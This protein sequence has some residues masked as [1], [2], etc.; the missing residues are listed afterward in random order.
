MLEIVQHE[1][2]LG[3]PDPV[4]DRV[5]QVSDTRIAHGKAMRDCG[6]HELRIDD[7]GERNPPGAVPEIV[8]TRGGGGNRQPGLPRSPGPRQRQEP[9][10]AEQAPDFSDLGGSAKEAR[11]LPGQGIESRFQ[12]PQWREFGGQPGGDHLMEPHRLEVLE[13]MSSE[14]REPDL[15]RE[16]TL[17]GRPDRL[18]YDDLATV[19]RGLDARRPVDVDAHVIVVGHEHRPR[20]NADPHP[21]RSL[22]RPGLAGQRTLRIDGGGERVGRV[23]KDHEEA[24]AFGSPLRSSMG[25]ECRSKDRPMTCSK[26][27][28][29]GRSDA[30]LQ[31]ARAFDI[32]EQERHAA[33][34]KATV[35]AGRSWRRRARF[36][37]HRRVS[38]VIGASRPSS[39][40]LSQ[41]ERHQ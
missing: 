1:E 11:Q 33:G 25:A 38:A 36:G 40:R 32:G 5:D 17:K 7:G 10:R 14:V 6:S 23:A 4:R 20:V 30:L 34:R 21:D 22:R 31:S 9:G 27:C 13:S 2:Q 3:G 8:E 24:V 19:G 26:T 37:R 18:G 29:P 35:R 16:T 41:P 39:A 12:R 28:I 15:R